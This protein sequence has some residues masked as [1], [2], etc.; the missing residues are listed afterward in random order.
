MYYEPFVGYVPDHHRLRNLD[1]LKQEDLE[2]ETLLVL[3]DG[4]CFRE[5][6]LSLCRLKKVKTMLLILKVEVLKPWLI[7]PMK[8]WA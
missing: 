6:A 3:E 1:R 4:H 7:F 2:D 5:Q 8:D